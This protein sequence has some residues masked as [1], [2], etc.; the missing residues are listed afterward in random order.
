MY[1]V[2]YTTL[3]SYGYVGFAF[4][5]VISSSI[6]PF[7]S[8]IAR[9]HSSQPLRIY[10]YRLGLVVGLSLMWLLLAS[11]LYQPVFRG[12]NLLWAEPWYHYAQM[13]GASRG[14]LSSIAWVV[15]ALIDWP[16][17]AKSPN[18]A[19]EPTPTAP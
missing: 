16:K 9:L 8:Y 13:I 19:L 15:V 12:E 18:T 10:L 17:H 14:S 6:Y 2:N 4:T 5:V 3:I 1:S 7:A 11:L